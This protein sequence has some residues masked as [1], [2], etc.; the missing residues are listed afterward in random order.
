MF[1]HLECKFFTKKVSISQVKLKI[2]LIYVEESNYLKPIVKYMDFSL[3]PTLIIM[4]LAYVLNLIGLAVKNIL[5][6]RLLL[7]SGQ[8]ILIYTGY[9]RGNWI[10]MFWNA[11]FLVINLYRAILLLLEKRPVK[12]PDALKDI[13]EDSFFH[14][15]D[16][17]FLRF[18]G[19]GKEYNFLGG[20]IIEGGQASDSVFMI[21]EGQAYVQHELKTVAIL[22]RGGFIGEM[23]YISGRLPSAD[24]RADESLNLWSWKRAELDRLKGKDYTLWVKMQQALGHDLVVKVNRMSSAT[25][26][27]SGG[28]LEKA[29]RVKGG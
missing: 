22:G 2:H 12:I 13:Y 15:T 5:I 10:V 14:M 21:I 23:S 19:T 24:V 16:R 1:S 8:I 26:E 25:P 29:A 28:L 18:W 9:V 27:K 6:L 11:I 7:I 4:N 17:E 20:T 3:S